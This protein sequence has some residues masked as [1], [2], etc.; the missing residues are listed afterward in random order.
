[1]INV[2]SLG[3][4]TVN[5]SV[6]HLNLEYYRKRLASET[7]STIRQILIRL[8]AEEEAR[9]SQVRTQREICAGTADR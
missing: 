7:D 5:E 1:M 8:I 3:N 4:T 9:L 6:S 2:G